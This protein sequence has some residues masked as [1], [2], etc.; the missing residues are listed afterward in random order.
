MVCS[1]VEPPVATRG[2]CCLLGQVGSD[3]VLYHSTLAI[4]E[5]ILGFIEVQSKRVGLQRVSL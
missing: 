3:L 4:L 5:H 2:T 1:R